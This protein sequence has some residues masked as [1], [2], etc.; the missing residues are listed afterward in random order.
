MDRPSVLLFVRAV[1]PV[2]APEAPS[3][4]LL[5]LVARFSQKP[6]AV[7]AFTVQNMAGWGPTDDPAFKAQ[8]ARIREGLRKAGVPEGTA[9]TN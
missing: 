4:G 5:R 3:G 9:K 2:K 1:L 6:L 8:Q 7:P